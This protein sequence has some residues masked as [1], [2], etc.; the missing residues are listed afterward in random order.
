MQ[1]NYPRNKCT[2]FNVLHIN[3]DDKEMFKNFQRHAKNFNYFK[4]SCA[5]EFDCPK[6]ETD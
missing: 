6:H 3:L 4:L 2:I 1:Y 5:K